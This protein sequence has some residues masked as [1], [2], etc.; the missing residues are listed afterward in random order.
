MGK[1]LKNMIAIVGVACFSVPAMASDVSPT[2]LIES[3]PS[4]KADY[5]RMVY[6]KYLNG[7]NVQASYK[8]Y[9]RREFNSASSTT[10]PQLLNACANG[11]ATT[12]K[13]I[14]AFE[15]AEKRRKRAGQPPE[16]RSFCLKNIPDWANK[17]KDIFLDPIFES[18]PYIKQ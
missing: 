9:N 12:L 13:D 16:T 14:K 15:K 18:M 8:A 1:L 17:N 4:D 10:S 11:P 6:V 3:M 2:I 5:R 7:P